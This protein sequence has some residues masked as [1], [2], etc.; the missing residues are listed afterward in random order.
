MLCAQQ[1]LIQFIIVS[2]IYLQ[3]IK[4]GQQPEQELLANF[5]DSKW[6]TYCLYSLY[7]MFLCV[8]V[9][10]RIFVRLV[11]PI[12]KTMCLHQLFS[13]DFLNAAYYHY[14]GEPDVLTVGSCSAICWEFRKCWCF[15][16]MHNS[17]YKL[18]FVL[19]KN[20]DKKRVM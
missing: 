20:T 15:A 12:Y 16:L 2:S 13:W 5:N 18:Y 9:L 7:V 10:K 3:N 19:G 8:H 6:E 4:V 17:S 11:K 1:Q 14:Y